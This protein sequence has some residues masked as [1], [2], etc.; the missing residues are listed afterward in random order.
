MV[1]CRVDEDQYPLPKPVFDLPCHDTC[2][3][4]EQFNVDLE[5]WQPICDDCGVN[6]YSVGGGGI[7]IDGAMGAFSS[8]DV[9]GNSMPHRMNLSCKINSPGYPSLKHGDQC[10]PWTKTGTSLKAYHSSLDNVI[11]DFD[12]T[13]PVYFETSGSVSFKYRKDSI[14]N[15]E[16]INGIFKFLVD[17]DIVFKDKEIKN[18]GW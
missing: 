11:V 7:R 5:T 1:Y 6:T 15:A 2:Q 3:D 13:Y 10:T 14:G 12:I 16:N 17:D 8:S 18:D 4:G 9:E